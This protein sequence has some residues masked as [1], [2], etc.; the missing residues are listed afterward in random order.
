M[1]IRMGNGDDMRL[2]SL[3]LETGLRWSDPAWL[4]DLEQTEAQCRAYLEEQRWPEGVLCLRC[5]SREIGRLASRR[6]FYCRNCRYQFSVTSGTVMHNSHLPVWKWFLTIRLMIDSR[7]G[8]PANQLVKVLGGSYK[9]AW[10]AE[11][12][13]REAIRVARGGEEEPH[14]RPMMGPLPPDTRLYGRRAGPYRQMG[15]KHLPRYLSEARW[16]AGASSKPDA[17]RQTVLALLHADPLSYGELTGTA[18]GRALDRA[19]AR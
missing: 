10:F 5:S 12:R 8:I 13:V 3:D 9:T 18:P 6:R 1:V 2:G 14:S 4:R 17:F 19:S 7:D 16:R 11:H 15:A